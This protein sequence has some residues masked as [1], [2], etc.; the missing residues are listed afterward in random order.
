MFSFAHLFRP[1]VF[2]R[3]LG[4][5]A[6]R[7]PTRTPRCRCGPS[8]RSVA[9]ALVVQNRENWQVNH[10]EVLRARRA[11]QAHANPHGQK[12]V[13]QVSHVVLLTARTDCLATSSS[14][15]SARGSCSSTPVLP[16]SCSCSSALVL[17]LVLVLE[18][19]RVGE[20]S[21]ALVLAPSCSR[22][23]A[24][25][26]GRSRVCSR[27]RARALE[28]SCSCSSALV[29]VL[30]MKDDPNLRS[31]QFSAS[32]FCSICCCKTIR[33]SQLFLLNSKPCWDTAAA[34]APPPPP[35]R[36]RIRS[37]STNT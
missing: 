30:P 8:S 9:R 3:V 4:S 17:V 25:A 24:R 1:Q 31:F 11:I 27:V 28:C 14:C 2:S 36:A 19:S 16:C 23:R 6:C 22:A 20:C 33:Q 5:G 7:E 37:S 10:G 12:N 21:R 18:C 34:S 13:R 29:L 32:V 26:R 15:S 35:A